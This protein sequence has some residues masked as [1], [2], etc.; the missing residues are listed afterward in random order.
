MF[1][2]APAAQPHI[3][4]GK[5]RALATTTREPVPTLPE[6]P[7]AAGSGLEGFEVSSTYGIMAPAGT[8]D[9]VVAKLSAA[10]KTVMAMPEVKESLLVQGTLASWTTV[11]DAEAAIRE[12]SAKWKKL[13]KEVGLQVE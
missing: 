1:E 3:R 12:E 7:T 8:P 13:I 10:L 11:T 5:L 2:T 9:A 6:V 4:T